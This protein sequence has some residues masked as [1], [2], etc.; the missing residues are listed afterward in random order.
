MDKISEMLTSIRNAQAVLKPAISVP[1]SDLKYEIAKILEKEGFVEKIEK[2][3]KK[4][5]KTF[6][7][8]LKYKDGYPAIS[9]LKKVSKPGQ[10]IYVNYKE[11][12]LVMGGFG[13]S[14]I[15]TSKG[16]LTNKEARKQKVGGELICEVW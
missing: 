7:I 15:S 13:F 11:I 16:V 4:V 8:N 12:K 9:G 10:R 5:K 3:G 2:K 14:V 1:Y 6:E